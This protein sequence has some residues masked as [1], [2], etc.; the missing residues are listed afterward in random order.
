MG[1]QTSKF[2][3]WGTDV[4]LA[5]SKETAPNK[6][7]M[8]EME[9]MLTNPTHGFFE[10][11]TG[12][13]MHYLKYLPE[14]QTK[15]KGVCV[16]QHGI[17][18]YCG[19]EYMPTLAHIMKTNGFALYVPDMIGHGFSEGCRFYIPKGDWSS[20][21]D[22]LESFTKFASSEHEKGTPLFLA[23]ESYGGCLTIHIARMWQNNPERA[24]P[25]FGG[26]FLVAPAIIGDLPP[27]I[28][29]FVL[30]YFLAPLF[31]RWIPF[32]MPNPVSPDRIWKDEKIRKRYTSERALSMGLH[33]GG[34]PFRLGTAVGLLSALEEVR[35][36]AIP[37]LTIPFAVAHGT[38]DICVPIAG[39]EFLLEHARTPE[40]D[41]AVHRVVGGYHD[42]F[43]EETREETM[44]F[45][46]KWMNDRI[47]KKTS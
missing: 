22:G 16:F 1:V 44:M 26:I 13:K 37:G 36:T 5:R 18:A 12:E 15:P 8:Q 27:R 28:V 34:R 43:S 19:K 11:S 25:G 47:S 32:F 33:I 6:K 40:D 21:R 20:N 46:M 24:P 3:L 4:K 38:D 42:I 41:R 31:P 17:G 2:F 23:G 9:Q 14:G 35:E 30:R 10:T 29:T 39:T 7:E 45:F